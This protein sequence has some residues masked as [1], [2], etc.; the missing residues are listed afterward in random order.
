MANSKY[1]YSTDTNEVSDL[2]FPFSIVDTTSAGGEEEEQQN[3]VS[4]GHHYPCDYLASHPF[5]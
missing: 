2:Q 5:P 1:V 4:G 3:F